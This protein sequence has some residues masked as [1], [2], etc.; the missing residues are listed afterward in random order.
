MDYLGNIN[1]NKITPCLVLLVLEIVLEC[2][3][4]IDRTAIGLICVILR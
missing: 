1:W 3:F 2:E 4:S